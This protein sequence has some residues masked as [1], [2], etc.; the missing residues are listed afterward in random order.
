MGLHANLF[1]FMRE[2]YV[3]QRMHEKN[4]KIEITCVGWCSSAVAFDPPPC[5]YFWLPSPLF[6]TLIDLM[7]CLCSLFRAIDSRKREAQEEG[8]SF[9]TCKS[10]SHHCL[11]NIINS[12]SGG[13][14][15]LVLSHIQIGK[16]KRRSFIL[17]LKIDPFKTQSSL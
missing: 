1:A 3:D 5:H 2:I 9:I 13:V 12:V 14:N 11:I 17:V 15:Y 16:G 7:H 8:C 10:L 4:I 6:S